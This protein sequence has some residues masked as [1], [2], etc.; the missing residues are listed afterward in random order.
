L[1][2][3]KGGR[4]GG[5]GGGRGVGGGGGGRG[6]N[7]HP[8]SFQGLIFMDIRCPPNTLGKLSQCFAKNFL[9]FIYHL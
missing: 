5:G 6:S 8:F 2:E 3:A 7:A 1:K 4:E 9:I